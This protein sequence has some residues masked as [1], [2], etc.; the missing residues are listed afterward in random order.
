MWFLVLGFTKPYDII[1]LHRLQDSVQSERSLRCHVQ[2]AVQVYVVF[3]FKSSCATSCEAHREHTDVWHFA[4]RDEYNRASA[5]MLIRLRMKLEMLRG[6]MKI[7]FTFSE[8]ATLLD[9]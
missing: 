2:H 3:Q 7:C 5:S 4:T 1:V 6:R 9:Q 8:S